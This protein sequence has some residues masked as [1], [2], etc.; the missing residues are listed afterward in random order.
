MIPLLNGS[1]KS[2]WPKG[3]WKPGGKKT[4]KLPQN[5][6]MGAIRKYLLDIEVIKKGENYDDDEIIKLFYTQVTNRQMASAESFVD[7][8]YRMWTIAG[9]RYNATLNS[10]LRIPCSAK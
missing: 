4:T 6:L 2:G 3:F 9:P 5:R 7:Y 8:L 10:I 1:S